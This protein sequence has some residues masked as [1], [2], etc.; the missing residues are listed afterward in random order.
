LRQPTDFSKEMSPARLSQSIYKNLVSV[1]SQ[2]KKRSAQKPDLALL[3]FSSPW[4]ISQTKIVTVRRNQPFKIERELF[5]K[6]IKDEAQIFKR[7]WRGVFL[8]KEHASFIEQA[9][10]KTVLN[11]YT[12]KNP[13]GKSA[14][15]LN[16]Y[17][18]L[19][20]C[21][22]AIKENIKEA[23]SD[24][25]NINSIYT[26]TFPFV[27]LNVLKHLINTK[28]GALFI[29]IS[30]EITDVFIIRDNVIEE[31]NSFPKGENF[32]IRRLAS[33]FNLNVD[34]ARARLQQ[35]RRGELDNNY[36]KKIKEVLSMAGEEWGKYSKQMLSEI[37]QDKYLPQNL[38]FCGPTALLKEISEQ[39]LSE[40]FA[41]FTMFGRPFNTQ[42]LMPDSLKYHFDF[43]KGFSDNKDIFLLIS[44]LFAANFLNN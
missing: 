25:L 18:Y 17:V 12:I 27:L 39:V 22:K 2:I 31:V 16:L 43:K 5:K 34:G 30:G 36:A 6:L 11:G 38:Y 21:P 29:D 40:N 13:F 4:Y 35:Y 33:A 19:S 28:E 7:K 20:L 9:P 32:L 1:T 26:H 14:N 23:V 42:F 8:K 24:C 44:S 37:A 3:V 41:Q 15:K 10:I